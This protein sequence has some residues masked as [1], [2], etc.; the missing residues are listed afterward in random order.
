MRSLSKKEQKD[1]N[2]GSE[3]GYKLGYYFTKGMTKV[4]DGIEW[5]NDQFG[6]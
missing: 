6:Y 2:G 5:V 1:I 4:M 3:F